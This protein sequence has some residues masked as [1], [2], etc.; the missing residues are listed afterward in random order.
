M[1]SVSRHK[2]TKFGMLPGDLG[3]GTKIAC[4]E[5][6]GSLPFAKTFKRDF[7]RMANRRWRRRPVDLDE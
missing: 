3:L 7:V 4:I 2:R 5:G 1:A 6:R